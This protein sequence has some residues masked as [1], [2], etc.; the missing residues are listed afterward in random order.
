MP[1]CFCNTHNHKTVAIPT[2]CNEN[3]IKKNPIQ[4]KLIILPSN[5]RLIP[6]QRPPYN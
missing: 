1:N 6:R 2:P 4:P 5:Y 3:Q